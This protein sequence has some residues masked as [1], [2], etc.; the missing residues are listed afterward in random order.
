MVQPTDG[1]PLRVVPLDE[2]RFP[3]WD[4]FVEGH[5]QATFFHRAGWARVLNQVFGHEPHYLLAERD[6]RVEGVLPLA[7]VRSRLFGDALI[8]TPFCVYGGL[9]AENEATVAAL[10]QAACE[11]AEA[12]GVDHLEYRH[13][14]RRFPA[15][16]A[17]TDLYATFRRP[18]AP[19]AE[20]NLLAIPRKQRR[21]VRQG[22]KSGLRSDWDADA[23]RFYP[24]YAGSVH[25]LGTPVFPRRYFRILKEVFGEDC[26]ILTASKGREPLASVLAFYFRDEV[27]PYYGGGLPEARKAAAYDFLY[28]ELMRRGCEAGAQIFDFGRSKQGTGA[29]SFKRNWGFEPEPLAYEYHL[30][31][32]SGIPDHNPLNPRYQRAIRWWRRL[33]LPVANLLGPLVIRSL[34]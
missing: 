18:I 7:R 27:L 10:D 25:R 33:P 12:L 34:A 23:S 1:G 6:G 2:Q 5:P 4:A 3:D 30:V 13:T 24:I 29:F 31:R 28:W 20:S 8:S 32:G 14:R 16:P 11:H 17:R 9:V 22:I 26:R 15:R 19:D 21:M